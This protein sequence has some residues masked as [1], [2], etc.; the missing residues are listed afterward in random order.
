MELK[1]KICEDFPDYKVS[2][3]GRVFSFRLNREISQQQVRGY[4]TVTLYS[5]GKYRKT[6]YIHRLLAKAFLLNP[7]NKPEVN[8]I[9]GN[10]GNNFLSNLEWVTHSENMKH[11]WNTG[12]L[13]LS[14]EV[15][16]K[17]SITRSSRKHPAHTSS[18]KILC[19]TTGEVFENMMSAARQYTIH[20]SNISKCCSGDAGRVS[21]GKH[22]ETGE[23]LKWK[24]YDQ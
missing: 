16:R 11:A 1:W 20:I 12:L 5:K 6:T 3:D 19:I 21:S 9:D 10:R 15:L 18:I 24:Y 2:E 17:R 13:Y 7:E 22:P 4:T 23:R 8:H 14:Q